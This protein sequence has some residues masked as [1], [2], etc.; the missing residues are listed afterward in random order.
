MFSVTITKNAALGLL[1]ERKLNIQQLRTTGSI[2][3]SANTKLV[4]QGR[5]YILIDEDGKDGD[6]LGSMVP[7]SV[8]PLIPAVQY[9]AAKGE[10]YDQGK[11]ADTARQAEDRRTSQLKDWLLAGV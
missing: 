7:A 5:K 10:D 6:N 4:L 8:R 9:A 3:L 11:A 1:N 2:R